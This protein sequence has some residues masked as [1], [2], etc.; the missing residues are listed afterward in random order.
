[1]LRDS[2]I[3]QTAESMKLLEEIL[4]ELRRIRLVLEEISKRQLDILESLKIKEE[5][6]EVAPLDA[7]AL[8]SLPDHLRKTA[9]ALGKLGEARA[10]DVA[11]ETGRERAVE[12]SYLNQLVRMGYVKK[13]RRGHEV[14]FYV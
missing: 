14:W 3:A 9:L 11:R 6:E 2:N 8:L 7:M 4:G 10:E 1:M 5:K 13:K 12:S